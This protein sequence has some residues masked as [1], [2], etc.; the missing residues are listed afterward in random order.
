M[1]GPFPIR[2]TARERL[3]ASEKSST[4]ITRGWYRGIDLVF[5]VIVSVCIYAAVVVNPLVLHMF[6]G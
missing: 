1:T 4:A 5:W 3:L 6:G 2:K